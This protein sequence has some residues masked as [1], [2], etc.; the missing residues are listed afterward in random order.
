M[1]RKP[2]TQLSKPYTACSSGVLHACRNRWGFVGSG[3]VAVLMQGVVARAY[4]KR[5]IEEGLTPGGLL[6]GGQR[7]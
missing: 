6:S 2:S 3:C 5:P 1:Q 7:L 4:W